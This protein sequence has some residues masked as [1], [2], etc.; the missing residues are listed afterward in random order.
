M[1]AGDLETSVSSRIG[2]WQVVPVVN[3]EGKEEIAEIQWQI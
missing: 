2:Q 1:P 3:Q